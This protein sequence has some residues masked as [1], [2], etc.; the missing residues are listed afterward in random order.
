VN[1]MLDLSPNFTLE[2]IRKI[3]DDFYYRHKNSTWKE[4]R[5]EI[6]Q[7]SDVVLAEIAK[8]RAEKAK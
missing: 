6:K 7:G 2:D 5:D 4:M 1:E 3:R 8:I